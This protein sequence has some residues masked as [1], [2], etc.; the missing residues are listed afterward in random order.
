MNRELPRIGEWVMSPYGRAK[1][2]VGH[3]LKN[4]VSLILES[5]NTVEI[6]IAQVTRIGRN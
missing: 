3:P 4:A 6:P 2:I 1:V 5:R